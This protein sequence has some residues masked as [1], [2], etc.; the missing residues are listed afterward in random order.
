MLNTAVCCFVTNL[1]G[2]L[3]LYD[4]KWLTGMRCDVFVFAT[5]KFSVYYR[6]KNPLLWWTCQ[7]GLWKTLFNH[8]PIPS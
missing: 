5:E 4:L 2:K 6:I 3:C 7:L 1:R 8:S